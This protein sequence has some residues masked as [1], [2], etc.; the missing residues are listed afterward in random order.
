[1]AATVNHLPPSVPAYYISL[2]AVGALVMRG[3]GCTINDMWDQKF[4]KAVE[5][6]QWRPL[7]KGDITQ[8]QALTFLGAQLSVGLLVLSQVS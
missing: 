1:M 4:D 6:T 2:F 3:A 7:A 8:F 5:R